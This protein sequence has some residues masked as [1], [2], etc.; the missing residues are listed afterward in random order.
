[1]TSWATDLSSSS[2]SC[3][4]DPEDATWNSRMKIQSRDANRRMK[5][6]DHWKKIIM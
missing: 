2:N 6:V 4:S 1:M 3:H 5:E